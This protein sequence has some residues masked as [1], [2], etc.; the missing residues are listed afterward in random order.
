MSWERDSQTAILSLARR[1]WE[2]SGKCEIPTI[3]VSLCQTE[4]LLSP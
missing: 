4:P 2:L 3:T 1:T